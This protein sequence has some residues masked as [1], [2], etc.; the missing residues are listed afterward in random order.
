MTASQAEEL[1]RAF[2]ADFARAAVVRSADSEDLLAIRVGGDPYALVH[3][4]LGGL[5]ADKAVTPLPGAAPG[6]LGISGFRGVVV[7][8]YDL[9]TVIGG[10]AAGEPLRWLV[11]AAA[12]S[13][14]LAFDRFEAFLRVPREAI[15]SHA[16]GATGHVRRAVRHAG[17]LRPIL[18]LASIVAAI[19]ARAHREP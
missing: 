11:T 13:V 7:P 3:S 1:A 5:F 9:R 12:A 18:D 6:L 10:A 4:E 19:R 8:V 17:E 15:A 2:D 14:A 16:G